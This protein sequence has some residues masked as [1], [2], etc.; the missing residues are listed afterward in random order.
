M[1]LIDGFVE[2]WYAYYGWIQ[3]YKNDRN[4][5]E[6]NQKGNHE[7]Y[8]KIQPLYEKIAFKMF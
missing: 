2:L 7:G 3:R 1:L 5:L 8:K 4:W 6:R